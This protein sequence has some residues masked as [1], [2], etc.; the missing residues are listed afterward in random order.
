MTVDSAS[1]AARP[2]RLTRSAIVELVRLAEE[3][4]GV[5]DFADA[6]AA[7]FDHL[8]I[9]PRR[10]SS[11]MS[12]L[13]AAA[14]WNEARRA[15]DLDALEDDFVQQFGLARAELCSAWGEAED[16]P[17]RSVGQNRPAG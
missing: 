13:L 7:H 11:R 16:L 14:P 5:P 1:E 3:L 17:P 6:L 2:E 12:V 8:W 15:E 9:S 10:S 4:E